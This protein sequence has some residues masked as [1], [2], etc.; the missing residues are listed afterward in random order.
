MAFFHPIFFFNFFSVNKSTG[1]R[2]RNR[3][4]Q[5]CLNHPPST[6]NPQNKISLK[7]V[8]GKART[9]THTHPYS[10]PMLAP[11]DGVSVNTPAHA[12]LRVNV[13]PVSYAAPLRFPKVSTPLRERSSI[14]HSKTETIKYLFFCFSFSC[15]FFG[16]FSFFLFFFCLLFREPS[17]RDFCTQK[18]GGGGGRRGRA[19]E[20]VHSG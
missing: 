13:P 15:V 10:T 17:L 9:H 18:L 16:C 3:T 2:N 20:R 5:F 19:E 11:T 8:T 14:P 1:N 4:I 12:H 7:T 6:T